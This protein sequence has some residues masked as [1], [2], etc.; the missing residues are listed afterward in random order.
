M[1]QRYLRLTHLYDRTDLMFDSYEIVSTVDRSIIDSCRLDNEK[2]K[3]TI[4]VVGGSQRVTRGWL[5][6]L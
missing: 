2:D 4:P 3:G 1:G 6:I 5:A